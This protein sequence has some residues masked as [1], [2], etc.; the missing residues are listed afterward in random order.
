MTKFTLV[1][2]LVHAEGWNLMIENLE[3]QRYERKITAI[4]RL[5]ANSPYSG[6]M[7]MA[8]IVGYVT[9]DLLHEAVAKA[10]Q[11]HPNLRVRIKEDQ[12]HDL[13]F[14]SEGAEE[15]LIEVVPRSS[16]DQWVKV[17]HEAC[18]DPFEFDLRPAIRFILVQGPDIA[19][20]IIFCHHILCDGLS[21]AYL[22]RDLM[23]H[24]GD[25]DQGVELLADPTP[26]DEANFPAD[27][28]LNPIFKFFI[29]RINKK[30]ENDKIFF[31]QEDYK[32]LNA[33]YW[34]NFTHQMISVELSEAETTA[35]VNRC[36]KENVSVNSALSAAFVGAQFIVQGDKPYHS[37][38]GVAGSLRDR[39]PKP[40]G[41]AMGFYAGV[42]TLNFKFTS[43]P[44]FWENARRYNPFTLT[45]I[46]LKI[47]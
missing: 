31:D 21:L 27:V 20:L 14:T 26:I 39:L 40:A 10:R 11:R 4:E 44:G 15:I 19:E 43:N 17:Y 25:P 41:E 38:I 32:N 33:A 23:V 8:R 2:T 13:W 28:S 30:W 24:L 1:D 35:I 9:E 29:N 45:K 22:A 37:K 47:L 6:V 5:F 16:A 3:T 12:N 36:R 46:C 7:L 18:M 42:V 34:E